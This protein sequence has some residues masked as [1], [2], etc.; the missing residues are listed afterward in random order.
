M[1]V[2]KKIIKQS[3]SKQKSLRKMTK[4]K[5]NISSLLFYVNEIKLTI[6]GKRYIGQGKKNVLVPV[7]S[8]QIPSPTLVVL[9][10]APEGKHLR[11]YHLVP[12]PAGFFQ[13]N[14]FVRSSI[15]RSV[16]NRCEKNHGISSLF[17]SLYYMSTVSTR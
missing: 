4:L 6:K 16:G 2:C 9:F 12:L 5:L 13:S 17:P 8:T 7:P 3:Y 11:L 14:V 1:G 10:C 15:V